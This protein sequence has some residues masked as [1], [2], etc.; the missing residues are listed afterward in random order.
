MWSTNV[1]R[2]NVRGAANAFLTGITSDK[3]IQMDANIFNVTIE[4][5]RRHASKKTEHR[6]TKFIHTSSYTSMLPPPRT[7]VDDQD[8]YQISVCSSFHP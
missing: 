4:N 7:R 1:M 3:G 8:K 5:K 6:F 2:V